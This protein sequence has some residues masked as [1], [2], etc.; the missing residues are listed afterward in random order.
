[1]KTRPGY[2]IIKGLCYQIKRGN[3]LSIIRDKSLAAAGLAKINWVKDFMPVLSSLEKKMAE[4]QPL[5]GLKVAVSVHLEAKTAYLGLV[6]RAAGAQIAITGSNPLST[7]D[8]ICAALDSLGV[9]VY[10]LHGATAQ[11]YHDHLVKTLE[12]CPHVIIDDGGDLVN[13]L[14]DEIPQCAKNLFGGCEETTTGIHR[15]RVR[16]AAGKLN[17][18]MF[19]VND[20]KCKY[21]F[22]NH[23][24]TGQS[25]WDAIMYT[26]NN[27][28]SGRTVVVAGYGHCGSGIAA[29]AKGLGANVIVTEINRFCALKAIMDGF[30]VMPMAEAAK[31]G[32][33]FITVTGCNKVIT[34][35]H[36][37]VMKNNVLLANAGHFDV[38]VDKAALE[39]LC[40]EKET[41]KPFIV[42][43]RMKDGKTLNLLA[44][45]RLVNIVA[46][47]GH[48]ADIMDLS[49]AIQFLGALYVA[50]N[51]KQLKPKLYDIPSEI[52]EEVISLKLEAMG[53]KIDALSPEQLKYMGSM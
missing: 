41:R 2:G 35:E 21:L 19:A 33:I 45:G 17:F 47:N 20:A 9:D 36:F 39:E 52:D 28:I 10:A 43:Y 15:L 29:R 11:E 48:P 23:H 27:M 49:F 5:K 50:K 3:Q 30:R 42:G 38:E 32:D 8:D 53:I 14:H 18:P 31:H 24:G 4:Q 7:K 46:G 6:L 40:V 26:T 13:L 22:D 16:E 44:D 37:S 1:M 34:K 25:S 12:F 51:A